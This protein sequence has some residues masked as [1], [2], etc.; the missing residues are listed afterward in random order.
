MINKKKTEKHF[1]LKMYVYDYFSVPIIQLRHSVHN[2][3]LYNL[4]KNF[5]AKFIF[6]I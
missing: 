5:H 2:E 3:I 6:D 1:N 4:R